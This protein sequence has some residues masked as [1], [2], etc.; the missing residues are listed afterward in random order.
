MS[1]EI[2]VFRE[3]VEKKVFKVTGGKSDEMI[4]FLKEVLLSPFASLLSLPPPSS[5]LPS[6]FSLSPATL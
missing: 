2:F 3:S 4:S 6:S 1:F 5:P